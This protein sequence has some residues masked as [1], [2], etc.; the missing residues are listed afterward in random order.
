[1]LL[2]RPNSR[3]PSLLPYHSHATAFHLA[4]TKVVYALQ[5][6]GRACGCYQALSIH[7]CMFRNPRER[8]EGQVSTPS[9]G[10]PPSPPLGA[11]DLPTAVSMSS[12]VSARSSPIPPVPATRS[13]GK[14]ATPAVRSPLGKP[15]KSKASNGS[16]LSFFKKVD[17]NSVSS[18]L[19][20][21]ETALRLSTVSQICAPRHEIEST[22][23]HQTI[24]DEDDR[25][26]E[27]GEPVKRRRL[28]DPPEEPKNH[29]I[30]FNE[31]LLHVDVGGSQ[32]R[33]DSTLP[34]SITMTQHFRQPN[35]L[36]RSW[37]SQTA[38]MMT[39]LSGVL[40]LESGSG[41][42]RISRPPT[43]S[44]MKPTRASTKCL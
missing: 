42:T 41:P 39:I 8:G 33:A 44:S 37:T 17:P 7:A 24:T 2:C 29:D 15:V 10:R 11:A 34:T 27:L 23:L 26:H 20:L 35:I 21:E 9:V 1:M 18:D 5:P 25:Y 30:T 4:L 12:I 16:I 3:H 40:V 36:V 22:S 38:R 19:F 14:I 6:A 31:N 13:A 28:S 43:L 32:E